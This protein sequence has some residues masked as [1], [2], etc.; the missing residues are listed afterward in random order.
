MNH[1]KNLTTRTLALEQFPHHHSDDADLELWVDPTTLTA[2]ILQAPRIARLF[3]LIP[4]LRGAE[5]SCHLMC[6]LLLGKATGYDREASGSL[7]QGQKSQ[8]MKQKRRL[9]KMPK[10]ANVNALKKRSKLFDLRTIPSNMTAKFIKWR[11]ISLIV[12]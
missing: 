7:V 8:A 9:K 10:R 1:L 2:K 12:T 3:L 6:Q 5:R 4:C 11:E